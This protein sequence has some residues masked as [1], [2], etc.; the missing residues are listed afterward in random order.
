MKRE[1]EIFTEYIKKLKLKNTPQRMKVLEIFLNTEAHISCDELYRIVRRKNPDIGYT[2]VYRTLKIIQDSGIG[3]E[4]DFGDGIKRLE[5]EFGHK[6]HDHLICLKCGNFHE[7]F[8]S[9]IEHLQEKLAKKYNF[10]SSW[11][12][13]DIFGYC[14]RCKSR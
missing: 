4:V 13:M 12:K 7:V 1:I 2:T 3:R 6:H 14:Q 11:H 10:R 8:D 5:H 9:E